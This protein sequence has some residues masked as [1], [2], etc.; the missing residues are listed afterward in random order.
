VSAPARSELLLIGY[1]PRAHGLKGEV[2]IKTFDPASSVLDEVERLVVVTKEGDR[3]ELNINTLGQ[4]PG[5]DLLVTF[6]SITHRDK[7]DVLRGGEVFVYRDDLEQPEEGEFF[8]GDL[9]GLEAVTADGKR[10][11]VVEEVWSTGPVP[12]LCIRDGKAELLIPFADD[13]VTKI[14]VAGG[15]ITIV[16]PEYEE[17]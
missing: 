6:K 13:F 16:P 8:H 12:N 3:R 17:A 10:V 1:I 15:K 11:G 7:A 2:V 5:A 4:A 14:D 9:V